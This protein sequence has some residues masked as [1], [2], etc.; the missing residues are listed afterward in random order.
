MTSAKRTDFSPLARIYRALEWLAFG[1]D[2][3]RARFDLLDR[4]AGRTSILVLGEGDGRCLA[5]LLALA[6][7][8][9]I[10]CVDVSP[11]MIA[12]T[13]ERIADLPGRE[14]VNLI[15]ADAL[16]QEFPPGG[17]D[18]VVT[19]F[20]LD[21]FTPDQAGML[22]GRIAGALRPG[23]CW[24]FADFLLP[25]AGPARWRARL[26]L[27]V[28]YAFFRWRTGLPARALP[29]SERLIEQAGFR[30]TEQRRFQWGLLG[31]ILFVAG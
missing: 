24:L 12:C 14:N 7:G 3:E 5:R 17:Y 13:A 11:G 9:R 2:L 25:S 30:R 26:W 18:A 8:A 19:L 4:L 16:T 23:A 27:S 20:F 6:P 29:P 22:V 28:L 21:C 1:G 31:A 10:D 15:C